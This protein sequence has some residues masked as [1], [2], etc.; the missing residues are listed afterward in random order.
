M[1]CIVK[2]IIHFIMLC[3]RTTLFIHIIDIK[4]KLIK[5]DRLGGKKKNKNK[6]KTEIYLRESDGYKGVDI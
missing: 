5:V 4:F 2:V 3:I 1:L 6:K